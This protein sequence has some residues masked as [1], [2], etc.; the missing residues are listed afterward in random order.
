[1]TA[2]QQEP[3][4][5]PEDQADAP[6]AARKPRPKMTLEQ[7]SIFLARL[8]SRCVMHTEGMRGLYAG[9]ATLTLTEDDMLRLETIQQTLEIFDL[10]NAADLVRKEIWRKRKPG[11]QRQ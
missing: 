10:N 9:Q 4:H 5:T 1:M 7:Q 6:A 3:D 8:L 2:P 11:G